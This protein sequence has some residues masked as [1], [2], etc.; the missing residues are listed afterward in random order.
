MILKKQ[1]SFI[2][3]FMAVLNGCAN[4]TDRAAQ[5]AEE[6]STVSVTVDHEL[7]FSLPDEPG[8]IHSSAAV[9][10]YVQTVAESLSTP[11]GMAFLHNGC[12]LVTDRDGNVRLIV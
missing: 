9:D 8:D 5:S 11:C 1:L 7:Y 4:N 2:L 10:F 6:A 3:L 12:I